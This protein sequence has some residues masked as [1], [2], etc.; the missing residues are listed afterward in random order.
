MP[1]KTEFFLEMLYISKYCPELSFSRSLSSKINQYKKF[2]EHHFE[3]LMQWKM[4][5]ATKLELPK[6]KVAS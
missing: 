2:K 1:T 5:S 4:G 3:N 6:L